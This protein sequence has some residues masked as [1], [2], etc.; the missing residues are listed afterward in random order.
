MLDQGRLIDPQAPILGA[1][2]R[3]P[4]Q[5]WLR[6]PEGWE[7]RQGQNGWEFYDHNTETVHR[8]SPLKNSLPAPPQRVFQF[9]TLPPGWKKDWDNLG[10]VVYKYRPDEITTEINANDD[11]SSLP[12]WVPNWNSWSTRDP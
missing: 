9:R 10:K 2:G 6:L 4:R 5:G 11:L 1:L 12:S 3:K 8:E 7:R